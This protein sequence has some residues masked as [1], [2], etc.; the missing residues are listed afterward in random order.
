MAVEVYGPHGPEG[1]QGDRG[2]T[3][4]G[5]W[6]STYAYLV[7]DAVTYNGATWLAK[8]G[9]T[10]VTPVEGADWT[11]VASKGDT[12]ATG[13][14]GPTGPTGATGPKGDT[15][16]QGP[17]GP[18]NGLR[19]DGVDVALRSKINFVGATLTDDAVADE[20]EVVVNAGA[21]S[22]DALTD[23]DTTTV[24]PV[25]KQ[26]L[27]YD[28]A[29]T[30][31][32]PGDVAAG[33]G[34][35]GGTNKALLAEQYYNPTAI[36]SA[37]NPNGNTSQVLATT[38]TRVTAEVPA[39]GNVIIELEA[40][41]TSSCRLV[42]IGTATGWVT[43]KARVA[44]V[45][46]TGRRRYL[47]KLTG[48]TP[49]TVTFMVG[50]ASTSAN[51]VQIYTGSN[52]SADT[53][54]GTHYGPFIMRVWD[55]A[56]Y[57]LLGGGGEVKAS[58]LVGVRYAPATDINIDVS[59]TTPTAYDT[60]NLRATFVA[61]DSGAVDVVLQGLVNLPSGTTYA[62]AWCL[63]NGTT[64]VGNAVSVGRVSTSES[65][66][67]GSSAHIYVDGLT[68]GTTYSF[69]WAGKSTTAGGVV[70]MML[71]PT[72]DQPTMDVYA[73]EVGS[74]G[75]AVQNSSRRL[76]SFHALSSERTIGALLGTSG[77]YGAGNIYAFPFQSKRGGTLDRIRLPATTG[78]AGFM[79]VGIYAAV[80]ESDVYPGP[81]VV[82]AG[83]LD[84]AAA[85][86][87]TWTISTALAPGKLYWVAYMFSGAA[88]GPTVRAIPAADVIPV[89][90]SEFGDGAAG[91]TRIYNTGLTYG[92]LPA[93]FPAAG[94]I[95]AAAVIPAFFFRYSA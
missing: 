26:A 63:L 6:S 87:K 13:P 92:P 2:L 54:T 77:T 59:A 48:L 84:M 18:I 65:S 28:A 42:G 61:P 83:E 47:W 21:S 9:N 71:G 68:P 50:T 34:S 29:A 4:R 69:D 46:E 89:L 56:L 93:T 27:V 5:A 23:V 53:H 60:T 12:G 67:R 45:A 86:N 16:L 41:F 57:G 85:A 36:E 10:N 44:H 64:Q 58:R 51:A 43:D 81:L 14:T 33:G 7:D 25:D 22:L 95:S 52:A 35:G 19:D 72:R 80:S 24:A 76:A 8:R 70:R 3:H 62:G 94:V 88:D 74:G 30:L 73:A 75:S 32:K 17:A 40:Y 31:W 11:L 49:G 66:Y 15:G 91:F 1:P 20:T 90:G 55:T 82:D 38:W 39:S 78:V 37:T 79:R